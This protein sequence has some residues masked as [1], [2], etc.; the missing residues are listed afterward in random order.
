VEEPPPPPP[1]YVPEYLRPLGLTIKIGD[2]T[3]VSGDVSFKMSQKLIKADSISNNLI[4]PA[5]QAS[6][7]IKLNEKEEIQKDLLK[8]TAMS[9][10]DSYNLFVNSV[11]NG[12]LEVIIGEANIGKYD[13]KIIK[14]GHGLI[15]T[16]SLAQLVINSTVSK[17]SRKTGSIHG[18]TK[19]TIS[20]ENFSEDSKVLIFTDGNP[21]IECDIDSQTSTEIKCMTNNKD[22]N[23]TASNGQVKVFMK[24]WEQAVCAEEVCVFMIV[25]EGL[26]EITEV[27]DVYDS[28]N[29]FYKIVIN[30]TNFKSE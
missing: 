5:K 12:E 27:Q 16:S 4:G 7:K 2:S 30:G 14:E 6:F 1:P 9:L 8:V 25:S 10:N 20:G 28:E 29:N 18:G 26:P 13:I 3:V 21:P 11:A 24:N 22:L 17:V 15:D 23:M 19:L